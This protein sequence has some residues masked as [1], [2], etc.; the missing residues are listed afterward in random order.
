MTEKNEN[1]ALEVALGRVEEAKKRRT[2]ISEGAR[3]EQ[4]S[5]AEGAHEVRPTAGK[6]IIKTLVNNKKDENKRV[7][8]NRGEDARTTDVKLKHFD[9]NA[10]REFLDYTQKAL[11][12]AHIAK[13]TKERVQS[14]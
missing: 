14:A 9:K 4:V 2:R 8:P 6:A 1:K 7:D 3:A 11:R 10:E 12:S 5:H 13:K